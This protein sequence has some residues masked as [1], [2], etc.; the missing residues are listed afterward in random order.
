MTEPTPGPW[1]VDRWGGVLGPDGTRVLVD[2]VAL[3]CGNHPRISEAEA[4]ARLV[5]A[6]PDLLAACMAV[7]EFWRSHEAWGDFASLN[8]AAAAFAPVADRARAALL[9]V[10]P[11]EEGD[12]A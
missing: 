4:N 9:K 1:V 5:A 12:G 3:P 7:V 10:Y 11:E 6:A 2:G 8:R